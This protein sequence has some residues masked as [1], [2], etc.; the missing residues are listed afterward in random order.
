VLNLGRVVVATAASLLD[1]RP[2]SDVRRLSGWIFL[3]L[4]AS[5]SRADDLENQVRAIFAAKC[6]ECHGADLD[7][8]RGKFGYV[9]DLARVAA[10]PKMVVP[11]DP[12][13]SELY[14][15]VL[16]NEMPGKGATVPPLT[17]VEK[18]VVKSWIEAGAPAGKAEADPVSLT[19]GRRLV[20]AIGQF[21]PATTHFPIAL[22]FAALPA[23]FIRRRTRKPEWQTVVR[24]CV[25]L[26]A[27]GAVVS[28]SLGWCTAVF[29]HHTAVSV[30]AW[31]RGLGTFTAVWA[32][33]T[34]WLSYR[35]R[36]FLVSL[37]AGILL[38]TATG[39]L[40]ASLIFGLNH[41]TW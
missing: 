27:A 19:F 40:G 15:M 9:L 37:G 3:L 16:H 20:R 6:I 12:L 39:Y 36:G 21:H 29:S 22:M 2:V 32:L 11:G 1:L 34:A 5:T 30:L 4:V 18:E 17:A 26:G 35:E 33:A 24:F 41:F 14:Q 13:H 23:E 38:V 25:T 10:N 7:R 28:A 31:H 8:P